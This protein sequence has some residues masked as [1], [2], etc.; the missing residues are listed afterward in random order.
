MVF[1]ISCRPLLS[2]RKE[3]SQENSTE[4]TKG[5]GRQTISKRKQGI[6]IAVMY[7][8][9]SRIYSAVYFAWRRGCNQAK[10]YCVAFI[11]FWPLAAEK[12]TLYMSLICF[13]Y[14]LV[15]IHFSLLVIP[16]SIVHSFMHLSII[17]LPEI[18]C[19][20]CNCRLDSAKLKYRLKLIQFS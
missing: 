1:R 10:L 7:Y 11:A 12:I 20:T 4:K 13:F 18:V 19:I 8:T 2:S 17:Y 6:E 14:S 16:N 9:L 5:R 3:K 15:V